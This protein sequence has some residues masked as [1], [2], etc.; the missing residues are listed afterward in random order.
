MK[1]KIYVLQDDAGRIRYVGKTSYSLSQRLIEHLSV[2]R[3]GKKNHRCNWMRSVLSRGFTP[4]IILIGEVD[5]NGCKGEIAWIKYFR[6]AGVKLVNA[7]DGGEGVLG[8]I[9]SYITRKKLSIAVAER[10]KSPEAHVKSSIAHKNSPLVQAQCLRLKIINKG[11]QVSVAM[12]N[13]YRKAAKN[14]PLVLKHITELA[15]ARIGKHPT[16]ETVK[17][18]RFA[19]REWRKTHKRICSPATRRKMA[20]AMT[21]KKHTAQSRQK[22]IKSWK[23]RKR[24]NVKE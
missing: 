6:D 22:M 10:M 11:R 23:T 7:T 19:N 5:G 16:E 15:Q 4:K 3:S 2:A 24:K 1:T 20:L 12:R 14:N 21:G 17:K 18:I 13:K 9:H 8:H